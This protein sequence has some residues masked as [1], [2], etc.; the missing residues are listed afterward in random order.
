MY[1]VTHRRVPSKRD[2]EVCWP[3]GTCITLKALTYIL[4]PCF[5]L[6]HN[7]RLQDILLDGHIHHV[8]FVFSCFHDFHINHKTTS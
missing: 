4:T 8:P 3:Y 5:C 2:I 1:L 6:S 7:E